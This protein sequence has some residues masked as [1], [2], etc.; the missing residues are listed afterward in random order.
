M[1]LRSTDIGGLIPW[2]S[3]SP[4]SSSAAQS[5]MRGTGEEGNGRP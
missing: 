1:A 4:T 2:I 5:A 3:G